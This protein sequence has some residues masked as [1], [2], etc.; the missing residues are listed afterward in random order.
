M[1]CPPKTPR[2]RVGNQ[3]DLERKRLTSNLSTSRAVEIWACST[4]WFIV[5][6]V[7]SIV[8]RQI[9]KGLVKVAYEKEEKP[10][11]RYRF[12][13]RCNYRWPSVYTLDLYDFELCT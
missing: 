12:T 2:A 10:F 8:S 9:L 11:R 7:G 13:G 3:S 6:V 5:L 1:T 4:C